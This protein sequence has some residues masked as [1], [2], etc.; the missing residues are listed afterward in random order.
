MYENETFGAR[1]K[2][3]FSRWGRLLLRSK[4]GMLGLIIVV[5]FTVIAVFAPQ[6][7]GHD[8]TALNPGNM[9]T[10]PSGWRAAAWSSLWARII[11]AAASSAG[12]C[13]APGSPC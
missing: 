1:A 2:A 5:L 11:W 3:F 8:P 4:T 12:S 9:T 13:T 6:L 7:A 10:P